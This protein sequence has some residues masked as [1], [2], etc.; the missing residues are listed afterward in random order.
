MSTVTDITETV[1]DGILKVIET[2]QR[3]TLEAVGTAVSTVDSLVPEQLKSPFGTK[4]VSPKEALD[5]TFRFAEALLASQK[6]FL[7]EVVNLTGPVA[8]ATPKKTAA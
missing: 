5:A 8:A 3:L 7:T 2:G 1:Q 6:S 4:L